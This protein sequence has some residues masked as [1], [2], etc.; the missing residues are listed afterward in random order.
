[1]RFKLIRYHEALHTRLHAE[2][3]RRKSRARAAHD[4]R[5]PHGRRRVSLTNIGSESQQ[6]GPQRSELRW[7]SPRDLTTPHPPCRSATAR[8]REVWEQ[9][10]SDLPSRHRRHRLVSAIHKALY[11]Y[12]CF[13]FTSQSPRLAFPLF[14]ATI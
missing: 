13:P 9:V 5:C 7:Q 1:M 11:L 8:P 14:L 12:V 3:K 10:S 4:T 6:Q 2:E